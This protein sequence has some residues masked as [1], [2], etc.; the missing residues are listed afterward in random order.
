MEKSTEKND[1]T[2]CTTLM[3]QF[4]YTMCFANA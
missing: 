1:R 4:I 3:D 2:I